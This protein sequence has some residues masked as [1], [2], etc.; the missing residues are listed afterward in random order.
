MNILEKN[1]RTK[2][3]I[4]RDKPENYSFGTDMSREWTQ[5]EYQK[6]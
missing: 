2:Y 5:R 4:G 1:G 6:L 3:N